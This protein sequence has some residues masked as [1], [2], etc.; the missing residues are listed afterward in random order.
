MR[1][2][3]DATTHKVTGFGPGLSLGANTHDF[4]GEIPPGWREGDEE[5]FAGWSRGGSSGSYTLRAPNGQEFAQQVPAQPFPGAADRLPAPSD[6]GD[7]LT[8]VDGEWAGAPAP[9]GGGSQPGAFI[10]YIIPI[11]H[12]TPGI[13]AGL[14]IFTPTPG[15]RGGL[16]SCISIPTTPFNGTTPRLYV[17]PQGEGASEAFMQTDATLLDTG[18][19]TAGHIKH[20]ASGLAAWTDMYDYYADDTPL[21]VTLDDGSGGDPGSTAGAAVIRL[22]V[23]SGGSTP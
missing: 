1:V 22:T 23:A 18:H 16:G 15:S 20:S 9:E 21:V 12:D 17:A 6:E 7:V 10:E 13:V 14:V 8:V 4:V 5:S 2:A 19:D 11:A 3:F